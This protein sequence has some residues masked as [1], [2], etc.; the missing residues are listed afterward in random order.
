M[1]GKK[2]T[3]CGSRLDGRGVCTE[4]GLD[5]SKSEKN[6]RINQGSCDGMPLTHVH[7]EER[8]AQKESHRTDPARHSGLG[9]QSGEAR[10]T[11]PARQSAPAKQ[12]G[13]ARWS[14]SAKRSGTAQSNTYYKAKRQKKGK[15]GAAK[16]VAMTVIIVAVCIG[17]TLIAVFSGMENSGMFHS[18]DNWQEDSYEV[19]ADPYEYLTEELP[20]GGTSVEYPLSS[21][22]Y[23]AGVHIPAGNYVAEVQDEFD[24]VQVWDYENGIYLYEYEGKDEGNYLNDLRIFPGAVVTVSS[25]T[26][27][28]F[29]S[30]NAQTEGMG[31]EENPLSASYHMKGGESWVAGEDFEAGSYDLTVSGDYGQIEISIYDENGNVF[32]I[33]Y[34]DMGVQGSDGTTCKNVVFPEGAQISCD[35]DIGIEMTP[36]ETIESTDYL[37][38]YR[39]Y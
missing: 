6:Y 35:A 5:N 3:L 19:S 9:T 16:W 30:E 37:R 10:R 15:S 31:G 12:S 25:R 21:G 7:E 33:D 18:S 4:C 26:T 29:A 34:L 14:E 8:S 39:R 11:G 13:M 17:I 38:F 1:F 20:A 23:I 24:V 36:G 28:M 27:I 2:C 22:R 32:E